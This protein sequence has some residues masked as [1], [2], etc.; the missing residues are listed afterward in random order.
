MASAANVPKTRHIQNCEWRI[1]ALNPTRRIAHV[2]AVG[3]HMLSNRQTEKKHK[4]W[5]RKKICSLMWSCVGGF[6]GDKVVPEN[7]RNAA[8]SHKWHAPPTELWSFQHLVLE[9]KPCS[10]SIDGEEIKTLAESVVANPGVA[11]LIT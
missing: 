3:S 2:V 11:C 10:M 1:L 6:V 8:V 9:I 5:H 7:E 4:V